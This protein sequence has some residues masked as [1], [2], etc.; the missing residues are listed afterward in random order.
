MSNTPPEPSA[1]MPQRTI[2]GA[3]V[4]F[5][6]NLALPL[7]GLK[8]DVNPIQAGSGDPYPGGGGKNLFPQGTVSGTQNSTVT[9]FEIPAGTYTSIDSNGQPT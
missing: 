7:V 4:S 6:T 9:G 1:I 3:V 2:S 8:F 5:K